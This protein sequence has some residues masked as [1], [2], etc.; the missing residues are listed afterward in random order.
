MLT[1]IREPTRRTKFLYRALLTVKVSERRLLEIAQ[2]LNLTIGPRTWGNAELS[3]VNHV[4]LALRYYAT[5]TLSKL[6][7]KAVCLWQ[8]NDSIKQ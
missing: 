5:G 8:S 4:I 3:A 6:D 7:K 2:E 1:E